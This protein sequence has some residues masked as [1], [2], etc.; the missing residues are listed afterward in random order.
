MDSSGNN[1]ISISVTTD[2]IE[3]QSRPESSR[4]AFAYTIT[5]TNTGQRPAKLISRHW[6]ITDA[7]NRVQ[8]VRGEGVVGVQPR[9]E[10][11]VSFEYTSGTVLET[12]V[13]TMEGSYQMVEDDG[14]EFDAQIPMFTLSAPR[15]LH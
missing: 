4:Y 2:Y 11:G 1:P 6:I 9:L 14:T 3:D 13:G 10:P 7:D 15:T 5:I 12:P 8:E